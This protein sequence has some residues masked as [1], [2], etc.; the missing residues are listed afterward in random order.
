MRFK[1]G[2]NEKEK[3]R[4]QLNEGNEGK[5][6][7]CGIEESDFTKLWGKF[8][9]LKKRGIRLEID[10][11]DAVVKKGKKIIKVER[12]HTRE[13]CVLACALCNMAKSNMFTYDEFKKVGEVI[14]EIWRE[15]KKSELEVREAQ[16]CS[17]LEG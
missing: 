16:N 14:E 9:G 4:K 11:K 1:L 15:R 12:R 7:Y 17:R 8:Y 2:K 13:N 6:H 3:L 5:C 10:R